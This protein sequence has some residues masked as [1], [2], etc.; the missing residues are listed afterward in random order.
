[1]KYSYV[2]FFFSALGFMA[3]LNSCKSDK[4]ELIESIKAGEE[5]LF[6]DSTLRMNDSIAK[7]VLGNYLLFSEK[8]KEDTLAAELLFKA[9][10]LSN[11]L[12]NPQQSVDLY[13]NFIER[14]PNHQKVAAAVFMQAFLYETALNDKD[15][16]KAKYREFIEAYAQHPLYSSAKASYDQLDAGISDEQLI[17]LFEQKQDSL[18]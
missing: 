4:Q 12:Q 2:G 6:S 3:V 11:G 13:S 18:K 7:V 17:D 14:Y 9:A 1:M 8:Y 5:K 10:D 16:A 15:K